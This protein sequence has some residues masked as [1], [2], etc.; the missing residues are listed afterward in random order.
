MA[1][2]LWAGFKVKQKETNLGEILFCRKHNCFFAVQ[3]EPP[4]FARW[5]SSVTSMTM[6]R[7][8]LRM[9]GFRWATCGAIQKLWRLGGCK[10]YGFGAGKGPLT[11]FAEM[12]VLF[13]CPWLLKLESVTTGNNFMFSRGLQQGRWKL[14]IFQGD[15]EASA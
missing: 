14:T 4:R 11:S 7:S 9:C 2:L 5:Q 10:A 13:V 6:Q 15:Q 8:S 12:N 3:N 1:R